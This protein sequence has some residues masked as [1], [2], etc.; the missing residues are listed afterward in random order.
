MT[1]ES[2]MTSRNK[3]LILVILTGGLALRLFALLYGLGAN[4]YSM[5]DEVL[6]YQWGQDFLKGKSLAFFLSPAHL[7]KGIFPG[8]L[9]NA[10]IGACLIFY[11]HPLCPLLVIAMLNVL[12]IFL[13][14]RIALE[15]FHEKIALLS[16]AFYAF[17]P[18]PLR[19]SVGLW[20]PNILPALVM[21]LMLCV[22]TVR[23]NKETP[24]VFF[25]P[26]LTGA[27]VQFHM[28]SLLLIPALIS[29]YVYFKPGINV[30]WFFL[31]ILA[32]LSLYAP[33]F[34]YEAAHGFK[35]ILGYMQSERRWPDPG[36]LKVISNSVFI[37]S[38][39]ISRWI[40]RTFEDYRK[41][42]D[43]FFYSYV[44][45]IAAGLF[46]LF[47]GLAS[48]ISF[49]NDVVKKKVDE[50]Y[51]DSYI[52]LLLWYIVPFFVFLISGRPHE[53][54][55]TVIWFPIPYMLLALYSFKLLENP[56]RRKISRIVITLL[57]ITSTGVAVRFY[58]AQR[59]NMDEFPNIP[60][61]LLVYQR[62]GESMAQD[63]GGG[64]FCVDLTEYDRRDVDYVDSLFGFFS[65]AY[66]VD[67]NGAR[68][69]LTYHVKGYTKG[70][71]QKVNFTGKVY[72]LSIFREHP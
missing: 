19:M 50:R 71:E 10:F 4:H 29:V 63:A 15:L 9:L 69:H 18:F 41:F 2:S 57:F 36:A 44:F 28:I 25:V 42:C 53:S 30:R 66:G 24:V 8:P 68:C 1:A 27:A 6:T 60:P 40:G 21:L 37:T 39:D 32:A 26:V 16:A 3:F 47:Y 52:F 22:L 35:D 5:G 11:R 48:Y 13:S 65:Y 56:R 31:G 20:N 67:F 12:C 51:K 58:H 59:W 49:F 62:L 70:D 43:R 45:V 34:Y 64:G 17:S 72:Q 33:F 55:Y 14:Y 38:S 54:R 61:S 46:S 23:K 7:N